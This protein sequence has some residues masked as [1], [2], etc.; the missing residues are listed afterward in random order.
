MSKNYTFS[1]PFLYLKISHPF[2]RK[3]DLISPFVGAVVGM[4]GVLL[5]PH[6]DLFGTP[7]LIVGINTLLQ[8][9]VGFFVT[10]LSVT[11]SFK[12]D[13]Y[14][15]DECFEGTSAKL[16]GIDLTR[17]QFLSHLFCYLA[18]ASLLLYLCGVLSLTIATTFRGNVS[19]FYLSMERIFFTSFYLSIFS[20]IIGSC[21]IGLIFMSVRF[22][23]ISP[24]DQY[25]V[26]PADEDNEDK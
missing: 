14:K 1:A 6:L 10:S 21:L 17:R 9:L 11:A 26:L 8:I 19:Y 15:I 24:R 12:G 20:H 2:K 5:I 3:I 22:T 18:C 25:T 16:D 4:L 23:R 7:G 13:V